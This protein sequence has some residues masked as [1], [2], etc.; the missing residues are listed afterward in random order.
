MQ[1]S[2]KRQR[3]TLIELLVVVT[4][5][6]I[7][8][9]LLL[10]VMGQARDQARTQ[11]CANNLRQQ[12]LAF[13]L[14]GDEFDGRLPFLGYW[15]GHHAMTY[16]MFQ[17]ASPSY[18]AT[19]P[20]QPVGYGML[21]QVGLL[22]GPAN[23]VFFRCPKLGANSGF[24]SSRGV[25]SHGNYTDWPGPHGWANLRAAYLRRVFPGEAYLRGAQL[26]RLEPMEGFSAD[27]FSMGTAVLDRHRTGVNVQRVDGSVFYYR[28]DQTV[29]LRDPLRDD[30]GGNGPGIPPLWRTMTGHN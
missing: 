9:S 14:Y 17:P 2:L 30:Y 16:I 11:L 12:S 18:Y 8:A 22:P 27:V 10:P 15:V 26:H 23:D 21:Y 29:W 1:R 5:I 25:A 19:Y 7:L 20:M 24:S 13:A 3:F 28:E 6:A 4:I